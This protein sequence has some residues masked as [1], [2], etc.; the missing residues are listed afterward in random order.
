MSLVDAAYARTLLGNR[1]EK[2]SLTTMSMPQAKVAPIDAPAEMNTMR[3]RFEYLNCR[4]GVS[5]N[6]HERNARPID[7]S[8]TRNPAGIESVPDVRYFRKQTIGQCQR[9]KE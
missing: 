2:P 7:T 3:R 1:E 5:T 6:F 4:K 9:Y 8:T